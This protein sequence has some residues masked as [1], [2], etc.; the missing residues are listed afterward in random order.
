MTEEPKNPKHDPEEGKIALILETTSTKYESSAD[1]KKYQP[2]SF[3]LYEGR[4]Y[5]ERD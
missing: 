1:K 5:L 3:P 2:N 4:F